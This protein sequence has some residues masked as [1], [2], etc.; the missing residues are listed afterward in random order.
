MRA[1]FHVPALAPVRSLILS[2]GHFQPYHIHIF[3]VIEYSTVQKCKWSKQQPFQSDVVNKIPGR[4]LMSVY[5]RQLT[6]TPVCSNDRGLPIAVG[7]LQL[8]TA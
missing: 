4:Q 1:F 8:L 6:L 2:F 7:M 5:A 3:Y